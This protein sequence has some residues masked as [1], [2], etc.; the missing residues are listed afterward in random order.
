MNMIPSWWFRNY[1]NYCK[2]GD[3]QDLVMMQFTPD[4]L[5]YLNNLVQEEWEECNS[6]PPHIEAIVYKIIKQHSMY[7]DRKESE[8]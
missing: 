8:D 1:A 5:D 4:E 3:I 6:R 2:I 7:I